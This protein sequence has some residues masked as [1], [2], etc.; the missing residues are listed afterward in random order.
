MQYRRV[1]S[2]AGEQETERVPTGAVQLW[3]I[4]AKYMTDETNT[5]E[6]GGARKRQRMEKQSI[7]E[8]VGAVQI[9]GGVSALTWL[10]GETLVAGCSEDHAIKLVDVDNAGVI[11]Q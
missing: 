2:A 4:D 1:E 10:N 6:D 7:L 5:G 9:K 3:N 8:P 11:K